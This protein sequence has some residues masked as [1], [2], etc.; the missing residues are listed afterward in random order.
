MIA[1]CPK[2]RNHKW[3]KTVEGNFIMCPEC[4]AKWSFIKK[5]LYVVTGCSGIGKTTA[6]QE[7]QKLT[8]DYVVLDADIF[9]N[10]MPH[11]N[12]EDYYSQ[13]EQIYCISNNI[14]QAGRPVVWTMAGNID[15]LL[16][17]YHARFFSEVRVVALTCQEETLRRRMTEGRGITDEGWI[18]SSVEYNEYFRTHKEIGEIPFS[19]IEVDDKPPEETAKCILQWLECDGLV[20][21]DGF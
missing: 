21:E 11:E 6:A 3:D 5:P 12:E 17:V 19:T 1:I 2:C 15:K 9:Y 4:G 20:K 7:L 13:I 16:Q 18:L 8:T 14:S 10:I